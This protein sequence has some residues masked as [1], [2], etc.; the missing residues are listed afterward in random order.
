[1]A[2]EEAAEEVEVEG[3]EVIR[4]NCMLEQA[5]HMKPSRSPGGMNS[6]K[7]CWKI[8]LLF[9]CGQFNEEDCSA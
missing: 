3:A 1:V 2:V 5:G 8:T 9:E 7:K 4:W 6:S